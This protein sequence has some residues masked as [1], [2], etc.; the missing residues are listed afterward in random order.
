ME[1]KTWEQ[2]SRRVTERG[3]DREGAREPVRKSEK[4]GARESWGKSEKETA[5]KAEEKAEYKTEVSLRRRGYALV[6]LLGRGNFSKVFLVENGAGV[7]FA[8]KVSRDKQ[9]LYR[10]ACVMEEIEHPLFPKFEEFWQEEEGYL[11]MEY[12]EGGTLEEMLKRR[13]RFSTAGTVKAGLE[14]A[15]GLGWLHEQKGMVYRDVKPSNI[16]ICQDG[17][18]KLVD[19]GCVCALGTGMDS[20]AG[21]PGFAAP[22]QLREGERLTATCDVYGL[23]RTLEA[24]LGAGKGRKTKR[25]L[26]G[27]RRMSRKLKRIIAACTREE[28]ER[29]FPDMKSVTMALI[30][31]ENSSELQRPRRGWEADVMKRRILI[32][33]NIWE[34]CYKNT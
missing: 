4:E 33:K 14:L 30:Q 22:E 12:V 32:Q 29:R 34:S 1:E 27:M 24:M 7:R 13:G 6:R 21:T 16:I 10:E 2:T 3:V 9:V 11:V 25:V 8:C 31:A 5:R 17:K 20:V 28:R 23:G 19:V 18:V 15:S 26:P